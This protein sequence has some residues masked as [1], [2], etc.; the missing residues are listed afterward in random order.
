MA[1]I[2]ETAINQWGNGLALRITRAM[3]KA[4]G[5]EDGT[6]VK[7]TAEPGRLVIETTVRRLSLAE[8]IEA[9][10]PV[11]H[12]GEAMPFKPVGVEVS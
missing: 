1:E 8:R 12:G 10:D 9:F 6:P 11:R 2:V 7:V 5:V 4:A 3:A